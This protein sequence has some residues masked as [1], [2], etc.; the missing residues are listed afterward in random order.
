[1]NV[2]LIGFLRLFGLPPAASPAV[3]ASRRPSGHPGCFARWWAR[4]CIW[5]AL[6]APVA[7][8]AV[9]PNIV[10]ILVDDLGFADLGCFGSTMHRTPHIDRLA[11]AGMRFTDFHSN[12]A[13]C[14]PT[15]VA[16]LTGRYPQRFGIESAIGFVRDEGVPL[17]ATMIPEVIRPA[18]YRSAVFGKWHVGHVVNFGPNDQ[19]FDAS[20]CANNNPDYHSHVSRD[21]NVDW[22]RNQ[23]IADEPGY[24]TDLVTHH[25]VRF[26]LEHQRTP[27]FL[28]VPHFAGHFPYQGPGDPPHRTT[29][30][31]WDDA[32]KYGPLPK[33]QHRRA[34][35][36]MVEAVD[37]SVG[38]IVATLD[39]AGL[40]QR[41][42]IFVCSDNGGYLTVSDNGPFRGQKADLLEG[43]HRVLAIA[44]WP[45]RIPAGTVSTVTAM[46]CDLLPTFAAIANVPT[47]RSSLIDGVDLS[48]VLLRGEKIA[49]RT[50]FWRDS[51]EKAARR[52]QWKL[53][54]KGE[55]PML[56]DLARDPGEAQ[57]C[58]AVEPGQLR[59]MLAELAAW[60]QQVGSRP[61]PK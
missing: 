8:G 35:R 23:R 27:F 55:V 20:H 54:V 31:N 22:W 29:G 47:A 41:T 46:T 3:S 7:A 25:A 34:F 19:G 6:G 1:M 24:L 37:A 21:G 14:S 53:T 11:R 16:L 56:F 48:G 13:V 39:S 50:L 57:D 59:E 60:E 9:A 33:G 28:Y 5:L 18:G 52:A 12:G 10:M 43:G 17:S 58:S 36:E 15:R 4:S 51:D 38:R 30:R 45:G 44:N 40:R 42:L 49:P 26:I 2:N 32:D 61:L